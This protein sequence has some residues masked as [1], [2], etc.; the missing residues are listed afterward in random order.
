MYSLHESDPHRLLLGLL[1][2]AL[3]ERSPGSCQ[4]VSSTT[5]VIL[6]NQEFESVGA[7]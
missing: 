7:S 1:S 2:V 4:K 5:D 6:A 3:K